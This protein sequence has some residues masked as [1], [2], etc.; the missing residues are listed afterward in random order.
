MGWL[1]RL[2]RGGLPEA[3]AG[4]KLGRRRAKQG[5]RSVSVVEALI[6]G[7]GVLGVSA[8]IR[9]DS[10]TVPVWAAILGAGLIGAVLL[11]RWLHRS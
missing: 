6:V 3:I 10:G 2:H 9:D 11:W 5:R 7:V 4:D 8:A 1:D